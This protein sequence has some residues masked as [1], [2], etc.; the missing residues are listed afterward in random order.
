MT[1]SLLHHPRHAKNRK[2][3]QG[4]ESP[5]FIFLI[6][7]LFLLCILLNLSAGFTEAEERK[8]E[9]SMIYLHSAT[10]HFTADIVEGC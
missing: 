4:E 6:A 1:D 8:G 3:C 9:I 5:A 10:F 7:F 2:A